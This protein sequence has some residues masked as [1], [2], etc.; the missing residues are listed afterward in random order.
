MKKIFI[1]IISGS[2][3][4]VKAFTF[5]AEAETFIEEAKEEAFNKSFAFEELE[6]I[7]QFIVG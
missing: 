6:I 2:E 3:K 7:E 4:F 5:K 1:V